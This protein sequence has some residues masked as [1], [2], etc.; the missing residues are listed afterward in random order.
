MIAAHARRHNIKP[1]EFKRLTPRE[2]SAIRKKNHQKG[3]VRN[4]PQPKD[5]GSK[6]TD[7]KGTDGKGTDGKGTDGKGTNGKG[8]AGKGTDG[9]GTDGK[10][11]NSRSGDGKEGGAKPVTRSGGNVKKGVEKGGPGRKKRTRLQ[12]N[13]DDEDGDNEDDELLNPAHLSSPKRRRGNTK[14]GNDQ[15]QRQSIRQRRALVRP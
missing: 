13:D 6:G 2:L 7:G 11:G 14:A 5:G 9:K 1:E 3:S 4:Q 15:P 10:A 12:D 8:T